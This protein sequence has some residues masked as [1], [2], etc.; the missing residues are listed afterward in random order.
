MRLILAGCALAIAGVGPAFAESRDLSGFTRVEASA[1]TDVTVTVGPNFSVDVSGPGANRVTTR[2][3]G[4]TLVVGRES[5]FSWRPQHAEVR[6]TMPRVEGLSASSAA[7]LVATG[8]DG[9]D[10]DLDASSAADLRVSGSCGAFNAEA[11]SG[12]D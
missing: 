1:A 2:V 8:V 5:G 7:D 12:A 11:S 9:G 3:V 4:D 10:V 6:V